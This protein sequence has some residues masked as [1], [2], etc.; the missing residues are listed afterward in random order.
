MAIT[1]KD[2]AQKAGVSVVTVSR[3]FNN[4]PDIS[5][6][7][8][9]NIKKIAQELNYT[10]DALAKSLITGKTKTIGIVLPAM[11]PFYAEVLDGIS[12][13]TR[14][15]GY[16]V[17][18]CNSHANAD[19]EIELLR[20]LRGKR[21]DGMLIYPVQEDSRYIVELRNSPVPFVFLNRHADELKCDYVINDNVYGA[22]LA[23]NHLIQKGHQKIIYICAKPYASSGME[24]ISGCQKAIQENGLSAD[25]LNVVTCGETIEACYNLV[26]ELIKQKEQLNAL[27]VWDDKLA[28]GA[29]KAI[30][31]AGKQIPQDIAIVGY[32]DIEI[33]EF[34]FPSLTTIRQP[35]FEIGETAAKILIDKLENNEEKEL[36]QIVLKPKLMVRETA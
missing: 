10:P 14:E 9:E 36:K 4:K 8:K 15:R 17:V 33:S 3:A 23:V 24:R 25:A 27:F 34:L 35:S 6:K 22:F 32:D 29:R 28:I 31:E 12:K 1:M 16:G 18:V 7:T 21:V 26:S 2:I 30:F 5:I 19:Q 13:E 20:F 11:D